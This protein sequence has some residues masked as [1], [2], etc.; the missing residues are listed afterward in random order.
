MPSLAPSFLFGAPSLR[1]PPSGLGTWKQWRASS[2]TLL[3]YRWTNKQTKTWTMTN[4]WVIKMQGIKDN[5]SNVIH[6]MIFTIQGNML[7]FPYILYTSMACAIGPECYHVLNWF[8]LLKPG[9]LEF[10]WIFSSRNHLKIKISP[11]FWIQILPN[12]SH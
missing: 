3:L 1:L 5:V 8:F 7:V 9:F 11:T 2:S 4:W 10:I 12:K 6:F